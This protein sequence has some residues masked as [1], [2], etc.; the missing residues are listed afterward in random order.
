MNS[1]ISFSTIMKLINIIF[2]IVLENF[3]LDCGMGIFG[4]ALLIYFVFYTILF[5]SLQT[6]I[7]KMVS[8]RNSKG[9]NGNSKKIVKPA[10]FYV[11]AAGIFVAALCFFAMNMIA[12]KFLGTTYPVPVIQILCVVLVLTGITDVLCGYHNGNGNPL[13]G[14][15]IN[16]LKCVLPIIFSIF[17]VRGLNGYGSKVAQLLKNSIAKDAYAAMGIALVYLMVSVIVFLVVLVFTI[18]SRIRRGSEKS[19]GGIDSRRA[20]AGGFISVNGR[21]MLNNLFPVLSLFIAVLFYIHG[22]SKAGIAIADVY[23]NIGVMFTK[24]LL[25][26]L[27]IFTIFA[28]YIGRERHRL[29]IDY[30]KDEI[31]ISAVRSQ[32][33]IKNSF[34]ML[35]PPAMILSFLASPIAKVIYTGH[36]SLSAG[37]LKTGGFILIFAGCAYAMSAILKAFDK[38]IVSWLIQG[39]AALAQIIFLFIGFSG[40]KGDSMMIL[41]SYY[42]YF[43][44]L[45]AASIAVMLKIIRLDFLD[46]LMKLGKYGVAGI[47]MMILFM[48]L[49]KFIV[50]N[51]FLLFLSVFFG[52]LLYYLTLIALHGISKKDEAALKRTLNY[53]PVHFLRSRLRL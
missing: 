49:D 21:I 29:H 4:V 10:L 16:L 30:R 38:E 42:L 24:L 17:I 13:A 41:Y 22:A 44:V 6:G 19:V 35:I 27:L 45:I 43:M 36:E 11:V 23:T 3:V 14:N 8:I 5:S 18:Q 52:Y 15:I 20:V 37:Y 51:I 48:I 46:I 32:Y 47:V 28:E 25:P 9:I 26:F 1:R 7:A 40:N 50:M 39:G 33:M 31:K 2:L 53:Y 34:F 12:E